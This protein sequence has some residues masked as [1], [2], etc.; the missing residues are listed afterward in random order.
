MIEKRDT[1]R[2]ARGASGMDPLGP[3]SEIGRKLRQYYG[4]LVADEVPDR[5]AEL[6]GRL[7]SIENPKDE[8]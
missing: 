2:R 5:F 1:P 4:T 6:L 3:N 7:E 8:D